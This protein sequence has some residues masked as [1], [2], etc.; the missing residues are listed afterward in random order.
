MVQRAMH[1]TIKLLTGSPTKTPA[2][3]LR[4]LLVGVAHLHD[5]LILDPEV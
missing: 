2:L 4:D 3:R 5:V 1:T